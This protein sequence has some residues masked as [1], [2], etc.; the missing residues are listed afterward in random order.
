MEIQSLEN[1]IC[2][3]NPETNLTSILTITNISSITLDYEGFDFGG[4]GFFSRSAI[5]INALS[6]TRRTQIPFSRDTL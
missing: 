1:F 4:N 5:L 6:Q 3:H 2:R